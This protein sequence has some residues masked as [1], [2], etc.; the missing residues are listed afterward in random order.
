KMEV[1]LGR[2]KAGGSGKIQL[3]GR[4]VENGTLANGTIFE[5]LP[6]DIKSEVLVSDGT[7]MQTLTFERTLLKT[8]SANDTEI[9]SKADTKWGVTKYAPNKGNPQKSTDG[10]EITFTYYIDAGM[11]LD[12]GALTASESDY[13]RYGILNFQS[14]SYQLVDTL[15]TFVG[16]D[17][18]TVV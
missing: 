16:A 13:Q 8:D 17:G 3:R 15:P 7:E 18:N 10:K 9:K 2:I 14:G 4:M 5:N 11:L 12:S 1:A 6:I